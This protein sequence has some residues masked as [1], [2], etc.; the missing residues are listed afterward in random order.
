M[1]KLL[2][3]L[4]S[5]AVLAASACA[6]EYK[7]HYTA[8]DGDGRVVIVLAKTSGDARDTVKAMFPDVTVTGVQRLE[9]KRGR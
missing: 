5:A 8:R 2:L 6:S 3:I 1:K 4:T 7:V 9:E